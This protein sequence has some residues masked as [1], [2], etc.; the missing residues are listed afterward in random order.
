[1]VDFV[2]P[3]NFVSPADQLPQRLGPFRKLHRHEGKTGR[4]EF[5]LTNLS[6]LFIPDSEQTTYYRD[7]DSPDDNPQY[8]RIMDFFNVGEQKRLAIPSTSLKGMIRGVAEALSNSS[9]GVF[10]PPEKRFAFRKTKDLDPLNRS[11]QDLRHRKWGRWTANET[12]E[13]LEAA[14]IWR[15]DFDVALGLN[16]DAQRSHRYNN[17][18][19]YQTVVQA[20]LWQLHTGNSHVRMFTGTYSGTVFANAPTALRQGQLKARASFKSEIVCGGQR[21]KGPML[22]ILRNALGLQP[23]TGQGPWGV[24]F[25]T[26]TG[27]PNGLAGVPEERVCWIR[28]NGRVWNANHGARDVILWPRKGWEDMEPGARAGSHYI[29]GLYPTRGSLRVTDEAKQNYKEANEGRLPD[30]GNIV[31]YYE[32]SGQVMEFGPVAMFKTPEQATVREI[33]EQ[34]PHLLPCWANT[35]LCLTSRLFGWTP[36]EYSQQME[37]KL[38][39][40][41]RVR[42]SVAWSDKTLG[43]TRLLPLQI[44]GSPKPQYY[45]FYLRPVN[46]VPSNQPA[47]YAALQQASGWWH[48]AGLLRG[49][50]FYLHHPDAVFDQQVPI[51]PQ[52]APISPDQACERVKITPE[53]VK[54]LDDLRSHQNATAAVLPPG[55]E[56]KG[57]VEFDS[58]SDYELG[59]LLWAISLADS[60]RDGCAERAHKL[61]MGR[62]IGMGSVRLKIDH[63]A[64]WDPVGGWR[65]ADDPGEQEIT[66]EEAAQ[67]P[68][69]LFTM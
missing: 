12:I 29:A 3:F 21:Y 8:H 33:A 11:S 17:L 4:I 32:D 9:F 6:P 54:E 41:G 18:R 19:Q 26:I 46:G 55:A 40:A 24:D 39:V 62:P 36:E 38:P 23:R 27:I 58:L 22:Q 56:F 1:M 14:K 30:A 35:D 43:D 49:R 65:D 69:C 63:I 5:T 52:C 20:E 42:V 60:P 45:P 66:P 44:F 51:T 64:T 48:N 37:E 34:T 13:P 68:D 31:R 7:P 2:Y 50:K 10:A 47:Y 59:L 16:N 61:G 57:Y 67:L 28:T 25:Q 15:D 53:M